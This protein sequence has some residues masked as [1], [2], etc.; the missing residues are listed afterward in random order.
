ME[1][2]NRM[3]C[4]GSETAFDV[5]AEASSL[6]A[7]GFKIY[8]F[9]LGDINLPTPK[10]VCKAAI[11]AIELG[12]TGYCPGPG[13]IELREALAEEASNSRNVQYSSKNVSVQPGG[14]P[15]IG[16]FI[17]SKMNPG[18]VVLYP[19]PGYPIYESQIEFHGGVAY[20]YGHVDTEDG[21][22]LDFNSIE[23]GIKEGAKIIFYNNYNNPTGASSS[24]SEMKKLASLCVSHNLFL[25]SDEAYF[26]TLFEGKPRSIVSMP[27]MRKRTLILYTF[28]KKFAMTG[29]RLGAAIGPSNLISEISRLNVNNESCTTHFVQHAGVAGLKES[30]EE[31]KEINTILKARRDLAISIL[32]TIEGIEVHT[33]VAGFYLFPKITKIMSARGFSNLEEFRKAALKETGVSFCDRNHFG[34]SLD[35]ETD[36]YIR[37]AFSGI[38]KSRLEE[39]LLRF[40]DWVS[41]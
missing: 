23:R 19:N 16:K 40:K 15:I 21:L 38:S 20:P 1:L 11:E 28:S 17:M 7:R 34:K 13:I 32:R 3:D 35:G 2:A 12:K 37:L 22:K 31:V 10:T 39:G 14:K 27:D 9:H 30:Q 6:E 33:P 5:A 41:L 24:S 26:D 18:D 25:F 36:H 8:P 29:W 4:L